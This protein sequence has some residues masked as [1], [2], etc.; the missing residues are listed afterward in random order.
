MPLSEKGEKVLA[1]MQAKYG[2]E[3]GKSVFYASINKG[4]ITGAEKPA[5]TNGS[6]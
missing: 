3:K 4:V 5:N 1:A 2:K 6:K